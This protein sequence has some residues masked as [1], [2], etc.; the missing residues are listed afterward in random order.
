ML[1]DEPENSKTEN[2]YTSACNHEAIS[3]AAG[4]SELGS[5][6][7]D[8]GEGFGIVA[9]DLVDGDLYRILEQVV[10]VSGLNLIDPV[11]GAA[12]INAVRSLLRGSLGK[13]TVSQTLEGNNTV[14][15][16]FCG[17]NRV[18]AVL[19]G[20][21]VGIHGK[22][23]A[24]DRIALCVLLLELVFA[25]VNR[26]LLG[27]DLVCR[28][29]CIGILQLGGVRDIGRDRRFAVQNLSKHFLTLSLFLQK[30]G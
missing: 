13:L 28:G 4:G 2:T 22:L 19:G 29:S 7:I 25:R 1:S 24:L 17:H 12:V 27:L 9:R 30:R 18:G 5:V 3:R 8:H 16:E 6:C 21:L 11:I 15:I 26:R 10:A 23:H 20:F 14:R